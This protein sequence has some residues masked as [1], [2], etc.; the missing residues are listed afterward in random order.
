MYYR[1]QLLQEAFKSY[2]HYMNFEHKS[3]FVFYHKEALS[4]FED[5]L[6]KAGEPI[7]SVS[8]SWVEDL[9]VCEEVVV[10]GSFRGTMIDNLVLGIE[11]S[12]E[13][14]GLLFDKHIVSPGLMK[15]TKIDCVRVD[16]T[17][18]FPSTLTD[19]ELEDTWCSL[20]WR[21]NS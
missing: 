8:K 6:S 11:K 3:K 13:S 1:Q 7:R 18:P 4:E 16:K 14:G 17:P 9:G 2:N 5:K 12:L 19:R 10:T 15:S 20:T 21:P